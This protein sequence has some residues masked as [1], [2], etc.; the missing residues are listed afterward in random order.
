[1]ILI[2]VISLLVYC[3]SVIDWLLCVSVSFGLWLFIV[4]LLKFVFVFLYVL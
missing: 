3:C 1:M 2:L 4:M